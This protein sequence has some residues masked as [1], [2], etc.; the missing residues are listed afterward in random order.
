MAYLS[1]KIII[2]AESGYRLL[3]KGIKYA[4]IWAHEAEK[5]V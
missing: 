3:T 1:Q 2:G 4:K 5:L